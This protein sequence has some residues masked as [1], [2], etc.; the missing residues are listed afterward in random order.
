[1]FILSGK[2]SVQIFAHFLNVLFIIILLS[3]ESSVYIH[4]KSLLYMFCHFFFLPVHGLPF[5]CLVL[6]L[7]KSHLQLKK[8]FIIHMFT[9]LLKNLYLTQGRYMCF[10]FPNSPQFY[11]FSQSFYLFQVALSIW[12]EG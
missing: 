3:C 11:H 1:M 12:C 10:V 8:I 4:D 6:V 9:T 2:A 5:H 7:M